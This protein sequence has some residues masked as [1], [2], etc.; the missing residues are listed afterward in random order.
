MQQM[1]ATSAAPVLARPRL[2][3]GLLGLA[4]AA[5]LAA[6]FWFQYVDGLQPCEL[7]LAQRWAHG[8]SLAL[9][10]AGLAAA[11]G[12]RAP[13]LL[14]ALGLAFLG[15]AAIAGY[16]VGVE[17]HWFQSAF[18]G[19]D[20]TQAQTL[21]DLKAQLMATGVARCDE[22]V[23][24]LAGITMAGYNCLISAAL[25][26]IAFAAALTCRRGARP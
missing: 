11:R 13:W 6:A 5:M 26:A 20:G 25:A 9:G 23:W 19:T 21:E 14:A 4:S 24:S 22:I 8:V 10:I 17:R 3:A 16:H 7:C 12:R 1:T 18:C 2:V 15:G